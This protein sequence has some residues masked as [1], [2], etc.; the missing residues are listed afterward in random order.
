MVGAGSVV[1]A[2]CGLW[3][4]RLLRLGNALGLLLQAALRRMRAAR[5]LVGCRA[6]TGA[7]AASEAACEARVRGGLA[8][9]EGRAA[10]ERLLRLVC[11]PSSAG[12][13]REKSY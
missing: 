7:S 12:A 4:E 6:R 2:P 10:F 3:L 5:S 13:P 9:R 1:G 8:Q 11:A